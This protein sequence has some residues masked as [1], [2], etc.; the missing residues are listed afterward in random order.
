MDFG[1][2]NAGAALGNRLW[3]DANANGIQDLVETAG[4]SGMPVQLVVA[5]PLGRQR[6]A[7]GHQQGGGGYRFGNLLLDEGFNGAGTG[8]PTYL[9]SI[10]TPPSGYVASPISAAGSTSLTDANN[11]AGTTAT[12]LKGQTATTSRSTRPA[13]RPTPASTSATTRPRRSSA[14]S[15]LTPTATAIRTSAS[16]TWP[17]SMWSSPM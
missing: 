9:I 7:G 6:R 12:V 8:Q 1:Y 17:L 14:T 5:Y 4:I 11:P 3:N 2:Y 15:T 13:R 16:P 10:P